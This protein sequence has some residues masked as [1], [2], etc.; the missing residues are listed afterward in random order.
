MQEPA[1]EAGEHEDAHPPEPKAQ[2]VAQDEPDREHRGE[3]D[4]ERDGPRHEDRP[5]QDALRKDLKIDAHAQVV[6]L[7]VAEVGRQEDAAVVPHP[8]LPEA[9]RLDGLD[10]LVA[11]E[12]NREPLEPP[13]P[14][15]EKDGERQPEED[16]VLAR[17]RT[18]ARPAVRRRLCVHSPPGEPRES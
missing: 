12:E 18:I 5:R 17:G 8:V 6:E 9:R 7:G 2:E 10:G 4:G 1:R 15:Q 13:E 11:E 16:A 14:G 3:E